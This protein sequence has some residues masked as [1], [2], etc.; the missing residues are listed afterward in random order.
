MTET[1]KGV[2]LQH[3]AMNV[4]LS[5]RILIS[6]TIDR[7]KVCSLGFRWKFDSHRSISL[8]DYEQLS[9]QRSHY[10]LR[11]NIGGR[12]RRIGQDPVGVI[13][14]ELRSQPLVCLRHWAKRDEAVVFEEDH[15]KGISSERHVS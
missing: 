7:Q 15:P 10:T 9:T 5:R 1:E 8:V 4:S 12:D 3:L 11:F 13:L 6:R 14:G 2:E